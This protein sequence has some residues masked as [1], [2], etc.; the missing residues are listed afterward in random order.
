M[1]VTG[2]EKL[3]LIH[4]SVSVKLEY[5]VKKHCEPKILKSFA[6]IGL[7]KHSTSLF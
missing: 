1:E 5:K 3:F 6:L 2:R 4:M 7:D